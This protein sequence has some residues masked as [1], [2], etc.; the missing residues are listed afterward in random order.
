MRVEVAYARPDVQVILEV[1]V[2][3][4]ATAEE[5]IRASGILERFPEIDLTKQKVGIFS[6]VAPLSKELR[7]WDRVEIYRA[8][9]ADPKAARR[10]RAQKD[11]QGDKKGGAKAAGAS[12]A[13]AKASSA[14]DKAGTE[15]ADTKK[16]AE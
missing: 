11:K 4:G 13:A 5:A 15:A 12:G 16:P 3:E 2:P 1:D 8:L 14:G 10:Q 6:K 9:I 7:E